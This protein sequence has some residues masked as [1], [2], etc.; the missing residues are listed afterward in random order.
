MEAI[1]EAKKRYWKPTPEKWR[2]IGDSILGLGTVITAIS[3]FTSSPWITVSSAA[4]TWIGK[5]ITNF[6]TK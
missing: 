1:E 2:K 3:A 6:A 5:T 4:I